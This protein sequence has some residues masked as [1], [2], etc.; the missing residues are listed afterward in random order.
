MD[1][2]IIR[3]APKK[4]NWL[5]MFDTDDRVFCVVVFGVFSSSLYKSVQKASKDFFLKIEWR[6]CIEPD[7]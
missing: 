5:G 2:T 6:M 7:S 1:S 3:Q 4:D